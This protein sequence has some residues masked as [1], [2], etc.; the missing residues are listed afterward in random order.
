[1]F[2]KNVELNCTMHH[3][4]QISINKNTKSFS[5]INVL[6]I[7]ETELFIQTKKKEFLELRLYVCMYTMHPQSQKNQ[8]FW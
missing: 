6:K 2:L 1:M 5:P 4:K 8:A 7:L 3:I